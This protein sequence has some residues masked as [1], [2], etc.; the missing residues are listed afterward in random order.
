AGEARAE[1]RGAEAVGGRRPPPPRGGGGGGG[2]GPFA[3]SSPGFFFLLPLPLYPPSLRFGGQGGRACPAVARRAK[4]GRGEGGL[5]ARVE[6]LRRDSS[7]CLLAQHLA[8]MGGD[9]VGGRYPVSGADNFD[10]GA[11]PRVV[12]RRPSH[13]PISA[14][15]TP[16]PI[17]TA[18]EGAP[19]DE[20]HEF[21][22]IEVTYLMRT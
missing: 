12:T 17:P 7:L 8:R 19:P 21:T 2:G 18:W 16:N 4:A 10:I 22:S 13:C 14:P 9:A 1:A 15:L 11:S 5:S 6:S 20:A 3:R